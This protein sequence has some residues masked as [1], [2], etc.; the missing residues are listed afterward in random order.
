MPFKTFF[1]KLC[2]ISSAA[3]TV[4][5]PMS[6]WTWNQECHMQ[7]HQNLIKKDRWSLVSTLIRNSL[8]L[9]ECTERGI[10]DFFSFIRQFCHRWGQL[11]LINWYGKAWERTVC[12]ITGSCVSPNLN[13]VSEL[14]S[15]FW[16]W[17]IYV[18][19]VRYLF[20]SLFYLTLR[21]FCF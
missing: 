1:T 3:S 8:C 16:W 5:L 11:K 13:G 7:S 9:W 19:L 21:Q 20:R 14:F 17:A 15:T 10:M 12:W 6:T 4:M 18:T 2:F